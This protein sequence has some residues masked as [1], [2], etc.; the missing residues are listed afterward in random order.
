MAVENGLSKFRSALV[1]YV[2]TGLQAAREAAVSRRVSNAAKELRERCKEAVNFSKAHGAQERTKIREERAAR[3]RESEKELRRVIKNNQAEIRRLQQSVLN[4]WFELLGGLKD[5]VSAAIRNAT[6]EQLNRP[7]QLLGHIQIT[8]NNFLMDEFGKAEAQIRGSIIRELNDIQL[9]IPQ[10]EGQLTT[11]EIARWDKNFKIPA[12]FGTLGMM[13]FT[14]FTKAKG[15]FS[16]IACLPHLYL[17]RVLSPFINKMFEQLVKALGGVGGAMFKTQLQKKINKQWPV[18]DDN[19][20]TKINGYFNAL[21]DQIERAIRR[22][23]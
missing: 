6:D 10:Q 22:R 3:I 4:R 5:E 2:E 12:E 7:N 14:F 1:A 18:V 16:T 8:I 11:G 19:V 17:I 13:A 20:R 15:P 23:N 21:S 9:P